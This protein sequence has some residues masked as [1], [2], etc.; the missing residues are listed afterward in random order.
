MAELNFLITYENNRRSLEQVKREV[1]NILKKSTIQ[2]N[3]D[4]KRQ[5]GR[6]NR[7]GPA[8]EHLQPRRAEGA[9]APLHDIAGGGA[10]AGGA[11][12]GSRGVSERGVSGNASREFHSDGGG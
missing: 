12:A 6:G 5:V 11:Q 3:P 8:G 9:A 10:D 1:S 7:G 4:V 2:I